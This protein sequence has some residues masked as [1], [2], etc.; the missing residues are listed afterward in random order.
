MGLFTSNPLALIKAT[1]K[2][3]LKKV[4]RLIAKKTDLNVRNE[5]K[6]TALIWAAMFGSTEIAQALI[7]AGAD[8]DA[9]N[10]YGCTAL[11]LAAK[12]GHTD[13]VK[14]LIKAKAQINIQATDTGNT[15]L[16]LAA[17][18]G[19]TDIVKTLIK[20]KAKLDIKGENEDTALMGA[21]NQG[22]RDIFKALVQAGADTSCLSPEQQEKYKDLL[23]DPKQPYSIVNNYMV[24]K[25]EG[26]VQGFG[27][28]CTIFNFQ[29][30]TTQSCIG[31]A[32]PGAAQYFDDIRSQ[33]EKDNILEAYD[34]LKAQGKGKDT[35]EPFYQKKA[36]K[37]LSIGKLKA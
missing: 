14:T 5:D 7:Q 10:Q 36:E 27:E 2:G 17:H 26:P 3:D 6:D 31:K 8:I 29:A 20:A 21:A 37:V 35:P 33:I 24:S 19:H 13:I 15:A 18:K 23:C 22:H 12:Y 4:K 25:Y 28:M 1:E 16:I 34:F 32:S 9:Q 11:I 30:R